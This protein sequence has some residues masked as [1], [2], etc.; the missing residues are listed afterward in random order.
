MESSAEA[1]I[2]E[3][4]ARTAALGYE[5]VDVRK[6]GAGKRLSLQVRIDH[7]EAQPGRGVTADDCARASRAIEAWLDD[8][9]VLGTGYVLEVSS[10]GLERPVRWAEHWRR[11]VGSD[12][13]VKLPDIGRVRATILDAPDD[14]TVALRLEDG[15]EISVPIR[16][17]EAATLVVDW[18][19]VDRSLS[20]TASKEK[21]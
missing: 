7:A 11:F 4:R 2:S 20:R 8:T 16:Q 14:D 10:P 15:R 13:R 18:S 5:L 17:A 12:V 9:G 1:L 6:R 19:Q 3:I 21:A